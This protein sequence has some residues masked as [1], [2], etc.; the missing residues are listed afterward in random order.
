MM[1]TTTEDSKQ[2]V[3]TQSQPAPASPSQQ[4]R[5]TT[6]PGANPTPAANNE[7]RKI[8]CEDIQLVQNLIERCLQLY[9]N[10]T[11]VITT[12]KYQAKIEPGFTSL[13]WQKLEEQNP[14]FF[15]AYYTRLKVK[16]QIVLFN[17]LL[18]Q[19]VQLQQKMRSFPTANLV[20]PMQNVHHMPMGYTMPPGPPNAAMPHMGVMLMPVPGS[21]MMN[22][23]ASPMQE[24][25]PSH[26]SPGRWVIEEKSTPMFPFSNMGNPTD[27]TG[28][29]MGLT[30]TMGLETPFVSNDPVPNGIGPLSTTEADSS[31]TRESL[32]SL[33][34]L[35][36][37]FSLSDLTAELTNSADLGA[38]GSYTGS[39]FLTPDT[40]VFLQSPDKDFSGWGEDDK[41]LDSMGETLNMDFGDLNV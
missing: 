35:P 9:M 39:P 26:E 25:Y 22:G 8:S 15:K 40:E 10:Q 4:T 38:L 30:T 6:S 13:V 27:I 12:L 41:M 17:H 23:A 3:L 33:G 21:N 32:E 36:R 14:D 28:M 29:G 1:T 5:T 20:Q 11:E 7:G 34:Q 16:K 31:S 2:G 18:E 19:Q 37:N 24:S